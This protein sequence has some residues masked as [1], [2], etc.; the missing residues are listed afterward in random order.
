MVWLACRKPVKLNVAG[1]D[2]VVVPRRRLCPVVPSLLVVLLVLRS[3]LLGLSVV[4]RTS[5]FASQRIKT[6]IVFEFHTQDSDTEMPRFSYH[7]RN[8]CG[9]FCVVIATDVF[10]SDNFVSYTYRCQACHVHGFPS[11]SLV[12]V[13]SSTSL[14]SSSLPFGLCFP[15][16][17]PACLAS[18]PSPS[19]FFSLSLSLSLSLAHSLSPSK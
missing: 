4:R 12:S 14:L 3:L 7:K 5:F 19:H 6:K 11:A 2:C 10:R 8:C 16:C 1:V 9:F 13:I 18:P 17:L 15:L